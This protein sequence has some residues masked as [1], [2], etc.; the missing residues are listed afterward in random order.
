MWYLINLVIESTI[1]PLEILYEHRTYLPFVL[2]F[3]V[4]AS[5]LVQG[6]E[7]R[8]WRFLIVGILLFTSSAWT[9]QRAA[10]W[11]DAIRLY[12]DVV[13][14][15]PGKARPHNNL[16][17]ALRD[18]GHRQEAIP[19][20]Q[21]AIELDPNF[22]EPYRSLGDIYYRLGNP[23]KA[24]QPFEKYLQLAPENPVAQT[25]LAIALEDLNRIA[26]AIS[27]YERAIELDSKAVKARDYLA[28]LLVNQGAP[29]DRSIRL[30][31][32]AAALDPTNSELQLHLGQL[33]MQAGRTDEAK[34]ALRRAAKLAPTN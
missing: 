30:L 5:L 13:A 32:E 10:V 18:A 4:L 34:S 17:A 1:I 15:S 24:V 7:N 6:I 3:M 20:F 16:G 21:R 26:E 23:D 9:Y 12:R 27:H 8:R 33:L 11:G 28:V 19:Y 22:K 2:L 29:P 31:M 14:K 25:N